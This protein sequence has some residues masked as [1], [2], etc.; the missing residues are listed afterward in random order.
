MPTPLRVFGSIKAHGSVRVGC[1][2]LLLELFP[3]VSANKKK[4]HLAVN[5]KL[6][7]IDKR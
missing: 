3:D 1:F 5:F 6:R 7:N 2:F 4:I